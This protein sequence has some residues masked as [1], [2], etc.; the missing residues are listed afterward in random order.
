MNK[1]T[2]VEF[3]MVEKANDAMGI[4]VSKNQI[5]F[6]LPQMFRIDENDRILKKDLLRFVCSLSL[7]SS[8]DYFDVTSD[9]NDDGIV[10]PVQSFL[11]IIKDYLE[12]GVYYNRERIITNDNKGKIDWKRTL[13]KV[14]VV[15]DGNIIYDNL[16][17]SRVASRED[18][19]SQI[20]RVCLKV[21]IDCFGWAFNY[22]FPIEVIQTKTVTEMIY[23]IKKEYSQTFD[24]IKKLRFKHMLSILQGISDENLVS[25]NY[26][27]TISNYYYVF[28][29]MVDK[30][31]EGIESD[32]KKKFNPS[33]T[34]KL[35]G[36]E[37]MQSS[38]LR[39]DTIHIRN[40]DH[41]YILD[42][43]FYPYG[44]T[45]REVDLPSTSS[46]QKQV[47]YGDHV[48]KNVLNKNG[49]VRNAFVLPYNKNKVPFINYEFM[50][51][52]F[53]G[54]LLYIGYAEPAWREFMDERYNRV[55]SFLIDFNFLLMNYEHG[56]SDYIEKVC[57]LIEEKSKCKD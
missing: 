54:N 1:R 18:V 3:N 6:F 37:E 38:N 27:Y 20:Y 43:K 52:F 42:A 33:A 40:G 24:D 25:S 56:M 35:V 47:T 19:L 53:D 10:W 4:K 2:I 45:G 55:Y 32:E 5:Q 12:N 21:S 16:V 13:R 57:S 31:F 22:N 48:F 23:I 36:M 34:W 41:V 17:T 44:A 28:E 29:K 14:P 50:E 26:S 11:W 39:P 15:I 51:K 7:A 46:I 9:K 8:F 49:E 30:F